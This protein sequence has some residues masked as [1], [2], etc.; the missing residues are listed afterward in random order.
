MNQ[1]SNQ[2]KSS[3][4]Y[5]LLIIILFTPCRKRAISHFS[6]IGSIRFPDFQIVNLMLIWNMKKLII[7]DR[8]RICN[9]QNFSIAIFKLRLN[10]S[11]N[12]QIE[13]KAP[14][15]SI[16]SSHCSTLGLKWDFKCLLK[17]R[18]RSD[19]AIMY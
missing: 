12:S 6:K 1:S 19:G 4:Q 9:V 17:P 2:D 11:Y 18:W 16:S 8:M 15:G 3:I 10:L 13:P 5:R 7:A 14:Q